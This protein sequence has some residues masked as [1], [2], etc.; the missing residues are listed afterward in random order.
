MSQSFT[1]P[2]IYYFPPF[3]TRQ[4]HEETW[5]RQRKMWADLI[6]AYSES[7]R[8]FELDSAAESVLSLDLFYN[9]Q[10]DRI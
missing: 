7:K 5:Q 4:T 3:F 2:Q 10:I 9:S 6:L 8:L 1:F